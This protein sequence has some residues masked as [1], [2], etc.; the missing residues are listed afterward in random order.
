MPI[1]KF[2]TQIVNAVMNNSVVIICGDTG[3]GKTTQV[4]QYLYPHFRRIIISQPRRISAVTLAERVAEEMKLKI[5]EEVGYN[6][7][8]EERRSKDTRVIFATDGMAIRELM[9]GLSYDLFVLDEAHERSINTDVLMAILHK[10]LQLVAIKR[11]RPFKLIIMSA[12]IEASKFMRYFNT[13]A[14]INIEGRSYNTD[15]FNLV[16]P[17]ESYL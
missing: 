2:R 7:R 5:G 11:E 4:P 9:T 1:L 17:V 3:S 12:T 14:V 6:V 15:V 13:D 8:F 16:E 10:R